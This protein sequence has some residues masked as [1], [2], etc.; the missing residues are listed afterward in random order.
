MLGH[1]VRDKVTGFTGIVTGRVEY[2]TGCNQCLVAPAVGSD[3]RL[4]DSVWLDEQRLDIEST[5]PAIT[6]DNS[7]F[8]GFDAP[9]PR[10]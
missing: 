5:E 2:I 9:A 4:A 10:R 1:K 6:L 8:A 7:K 3:G